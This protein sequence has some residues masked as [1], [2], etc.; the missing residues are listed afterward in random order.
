MYNV[1]ALFAVLPTDIQGLLKH[2]LKILS[3]GSTIEIKVNIQN[4]DMSAN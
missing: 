3:A 2:R 4:K 1:T